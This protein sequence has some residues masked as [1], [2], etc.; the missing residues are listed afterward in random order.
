MK[1][2]LSVVVLTHNDEGRIVDCLECLNFT[3][4][5]I[6][7]D[8]NS[9]DRT[10]EL[11][12]QYTNKIFIRALSG[13]FASQ[14]NF[15]LNNVHNAWVLFVDSDELISNRLKEE[16]LVS[17]KA[18]SAAGY[19]LKR[20]DYMWQKKILHGEAGQINL[21]R[22]A[23]KDAGKWHGKVHET[24]KIIGR[25]EQLQ[26]PIIHIPH[27]SMKEFINDVDNYS[28]L[29]SIELRENH[30]QASPLSVIF[31]PVA[32]FVG[33]YFFKKG[34]KDGIPGFLYAMTMS[35]HSFLVRSKLFQMDREMMK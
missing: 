16:I 19:Y 29:R 27:Q 9:S 31:Y 24:W 22:L 25:I 12:K 13:N 8:D 15:A 17:I 18:G 30:V 2:N 23:R 3:D 20:I 4:E 21:I 11:A 7:V 33:N 32:K 35:F 26:H 28:T 6:I 1:S 34:Y 14:R 5:L 10:I